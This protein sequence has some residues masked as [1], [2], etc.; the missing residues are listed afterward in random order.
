MTSD[1]TAVVARRDGV[2]L[3]KAEDEDLPR[4]DEVVVVCYTPIHESYLAIIGE[5]VYAGL[6]SRPDRDWRIEKTDRIKQTARDPAGF[7]WVLEEA[8][9]IFGFVTFRVFPETRR[10]WI[11][12]NGVKP[13]RRGLGWATFMLRHVLEHAR[14][15]GVRIASVEVDLDDAHVS[16]RRTYQA[17]G[18]D[19][20]HHLAIYH[21]DL[22]RRN[23]GSTLSPDGDGNRSTR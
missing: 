15:L 1:E 18:F 9:T 13:E 3:R 12:E 16:A 21:Q 2:I 19:R 17:A 7:L 8:G 11:E 20:H 5:D 4:V 10:L 22:E 23:P 6:R 14:S